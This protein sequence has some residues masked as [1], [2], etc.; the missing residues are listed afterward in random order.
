MFKVLSYIKKK[1]IIILPVTMILAIVFGYYFETSYLKNFVTPIIFLMVY[2]MMV[3]LK[4]KELL[5]TGNTKLHVVTQLVNFILIPLTGFVLGKLFFI[6]NNYLITGLLIMSLLPTSGMTISWTGFAKGN[7]SAAIK[8]M[9]VGLILGSLLT[10]I[11][12]NL[13][14]G[15]TINIPFIGVITQIIKIVFIPMLAGY[16][17]Q[18]ILVSIYGIQGFQKRFKPKFPLLSTLGLLGIVFISTALKAK[19]IVKN[20]ALLLKIFVVL[21]VYYSI[22]FIVT[23]V[24]AKKLFNREDSIALVYATVMRNLSIALA[25]ALSIF[26]KKGADVALILAVAFVVQIQG[27]AWYLKIVDKVFGKKTMVRVNSISDK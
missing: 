10:P 15:A 13:F 27:A 25:I 2:P 7:I 20:P 21:I 19:T 4:Y 18:K 1:L 24:I 26:A 8:M 3:N 17:T 16:L 14:L 23:T 9:V 22:N 11:Y 5:T 6:D 12:L